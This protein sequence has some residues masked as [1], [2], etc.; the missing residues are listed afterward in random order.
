M[1]EK[2]YLPYLNSL[3]THVGI[4]AML[5]I[6]LRKQSAINIINKLILTV[7]IEKF[8]KS[9]RKDTKDDKIILI[10]F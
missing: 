6:N 1:Q 8:S 2:K 9:V 7:Y 5:A 10:I 4:S 3:Y